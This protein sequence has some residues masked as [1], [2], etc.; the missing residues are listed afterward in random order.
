VTATTNNANAKLKV[1]TL[2]TPAAHW[3]VPVAPVTLAAPKG[4]SPRPAVAVAPKAAKT[5]YVGSLRVGIS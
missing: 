3:F 1:S 5:L 4:S 2:A